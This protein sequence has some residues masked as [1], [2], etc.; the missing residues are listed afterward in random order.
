MPMLNQKHKNNKKTK[1]RKQIK[2][3]ELFLLGSLLVIMG[4]VILLFNRI[5]T[6]RL[7]VFNDMLI[8]LSD[9]STE[10]TMIADVPNMEELDGDPD[11]QEPA[12]VDFSRFLG[13]LEIP[14][15]N[16]RRGF[17]NVD[18]PHNTVERNIQKIH[19]SRMPTVERGNLIL[20]AHSGDAHI[21]FF[22]FLHRLRIGDRAYIT[23][24][25]Q[26]FA[27]VIVD[28]YEVPKTGT[29]EIRRNHDATVLTLITCTENSDYLQTV[30]I[31][32]ME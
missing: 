29:V 13:V 11:G 18:S 17:F 4:I 3:S 30:Y 7:D 16:L 1:K 5:Q 21:S 28:I 6:L 25:G 15:I 2:K 10:V 31:L 24:N 14:R 23:Y 26:R 9:I 8:N 19:G 27:Y 22:R 32:E 20:A 12:P